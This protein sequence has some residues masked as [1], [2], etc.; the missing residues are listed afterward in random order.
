MVFPAA[1]L[2]VKTM[3]FL[4]SFYPND[5]FCFDHHHGRRENH[6]FRSEVLGHFHFFT[7]SPPQSLFVPLGA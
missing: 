2:G 4:S 5:F 3:K 6:S 1:M 7:L